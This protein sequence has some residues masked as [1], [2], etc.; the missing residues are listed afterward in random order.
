MDR[1]MGIG[2]GALAA[3]GGTLIVL[4]ATVGNGWSALD[5]GG[6][7]LLLLIAATVLGGAAVGGLQA[8]SDG[9]RRWVGLAAVQLALGAVG[10]NLG[11][12]VAAGAIE[13]AETA[14]RPAMAAKALWVASTVDVLGWGLAVTTLVVGL[15]VGASRDRQVTQVWSPLW[16]L[17]IGAAALQGACV[18]PTTG[19]VMAL[20]WGA[21]LLGVQ[22]SNPV[23]GAQSIAALIPWMAALGTVR[24][25]RHQQYADLTESLP[26]VLP[27]E[28]LVVG[29]WMGLALL[30]GRGRFPDGLSA[31]LL[32]GSLA[33]LAGGVVAWTAGMEAGILT[34]VGG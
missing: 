5:R 9:V 12:L 33:L 22:L 4:F 2:L 20:V 1:L 27:G 14:L 34:V 24:M 7:V 21:T 31:R 17:G 11:L 3:A 26:A 16:A 13:R 15:W 28:V 23:S 32:F 18:S 29:L 19:V 6:P 10:T 25:A 8:R 30:V